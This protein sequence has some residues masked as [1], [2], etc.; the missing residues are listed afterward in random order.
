M[1]DLPRPP[2][3]IDHEDAQ[4]RLLQSDE[5]ERNVLVLATG[6]TLC[7]KPNAE[8]A[9]EAVPR[10]IPDT[11][12]VT[13][14][15]HDVEYFEKYVEPRTNNKDTFVLP[16][17]YSHSVTGTSGSQNRDKKQATR[18]VYTIHEYTP[19]IDSS[20]MAVSDYRKI[21]ADIQAAY[22]HYD[23][24]VVLHGTD[25]LAYSAST[26]SFMFEHLG[27]PVVLTGAQVPAAE[28]RTDAFDNIIGSLVIAGNYKIPE[29]TVFFDR[30]LYRGNRVQKVDADEFHAFD[31][32]NLRPL[33]KMGIHINVNSE[34][35]WT[36]NSLLS[37]RV[38]EKWDQQIGLLRIFPAITTATVKAFLSGDIRGVV[39][40]TYGAGNGP[41]ERKDLM[42]ELRKAALERDVLI[43]NCTQC[44]RGCVTNAYAAGLELEKNG[45]MGGFDM[46]CEAAL[47]KLSYVLGL[48][49]SIQEKRKLIGQNLRGELT[50]EEKADATSKIDS[51]FVKAVAAGMKSCSKNE[52]RQIRDSIYPPL[53]LSSCRTGDMKKCRELISNGANY[54]CSDYDQRTPLHIAAAEGHLELVEEMLK[55]GASVHAKDRNNQ[56]PLFDAIQG[57]HYDVI[58]LLVTTGAL[59]SIPDAR[60]ATMLCRHAVMNDVDSIKAFLLAKANLNVEDYDGRRPLH[61]ACQSGWFDLTKFLVDNGADI[62][63]LDN[64]NHNSLYEAVRHDHHDIIKFLVA[65]GAKIEV[66]NLQL[67]NLLCRHAANNSLDDLK[68]WVEAGIDVNVSDYDGRTALH[69]ACSHGNEDVVRF[70][71]EN[72]A[73]VS[74]EDKFRRTSII[75][76]EQSGGLNKDTILKLLNQKK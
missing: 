53:L 7:M 36:S 61:V 3:E 33:V 21:A 62:H 15:V 18:V 14:A 20:N 2:T 41:S 51:D 10:Y 74:G 47:A 70:L 60:L 27:K 24:F 75:E 6:G 35:I 11:F 4:Q 39:L 57:R 42:D 46:T 66:D 32:P 25:T 63:V 44:Q 54:N 40:Q 48:D 30:C 22:N 64:K 69:I 56:T 13:S 59:L 76:V 34:A 26:L 52:L 73:K 31:S 45:V 28:M 67:A 43:V 50:N 71:L 49:I 29:V 19:L 16:R 23:G 55:S 5:I 72:G 37:F 38:T 9:Y 58:R 65:K 8:G 1:T 17:T 68:A 12:K